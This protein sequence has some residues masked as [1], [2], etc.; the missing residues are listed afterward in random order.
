MDYGE[1]ME[2]E[3]SND[4]SVVNGGE[5]KVHLFLLLLLLLLLL[6]VF[7]FEGT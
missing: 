5:L 3:G 7:F 4:D 1:E 2:R 6:L